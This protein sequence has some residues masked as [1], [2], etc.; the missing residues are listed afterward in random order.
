MTDTLT[1][2]IAG[3]A[4]ALKPCPFCNSDTLEV[5]GSMSWTHVAC[6]SCGALGPRIHHGGPTNDRATLN[7]CEAEA[8]DAWNHRLQSLADRGG[9]KAEP[10]ARE[11]GWLLEWLHGTG[12]EWWTLA[13]SQ[14]QGGYF[15][16]D[17]IKALRFARKEDAQAYIDDV[18]WTEIVPTEHE[19]SD[20]RPANPSTVEPMRV[21]EVDL[22]TV[23][24]VCRKVNPGRSED[25]I[26]SVALDALSVLRA[27][28]QPEGT[29]K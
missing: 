22:A 1:A 10:V 12:P 24:A 23:E 14:G 17:S 5:C 26:K 25:H 29:P 13:N 28:Q 19:W 16:K 20:P 27:L 6:G 3:L 18:G 11:T 9:E 7:R 8:I 15:A 2:T 4:E 21:R